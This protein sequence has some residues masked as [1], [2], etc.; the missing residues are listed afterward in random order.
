M[1]IAPSGHVVTSNTVAVAIGSNIGDRESHVRFAF[2]HLQRILSDIRTSS[3]YETEPVGVVQPQMPF[4]NAAAV[5]RARL[6]PEALLEAL[7][8]LER[9]RG[10]E[11]PY[12]LAPRTL[13]LDLILYGDKVIETPALTVPHPR[14]RERLFVLAPLAEIAPGA[15]DPVTGKTI[16]ELAR[17]VPRL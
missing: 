17:A 11:R 13:D 12:P 2:D 14:F 4:L 3:V 6:G 16:G 1:V 9:K 10:R 15:V 8:D 7:L 5:G